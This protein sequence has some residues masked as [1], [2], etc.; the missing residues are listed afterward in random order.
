MNTFLKVNNA[1]CGVNSIQDYNRII[2]WIW[3]WR[4]FVLLASFRSTV[5]SAARHKSLWLISIF[6][7]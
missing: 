2:K 4:L 7:I 3:I 5:Q 6:A 1:A